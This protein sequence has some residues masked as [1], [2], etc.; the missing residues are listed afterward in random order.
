MYSVSCM[1]GLATTKTPAPI[2]PITDDNL[3][4]TTRESF[5]QLPD[6]FSEDDPFRAEGMLQHA[7][8]KMTL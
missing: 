1:T 3:I 6:A 5:E 7:L 8:K 4:P 2:I